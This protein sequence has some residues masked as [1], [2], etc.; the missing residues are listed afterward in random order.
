MKDLMLKIVKSKL[1]LAVLL[2]MVFAAAVIIFTSFSY[3]D[4]G[5]YN[6]SM[7]ICK[8]HFYYNSNINYI[9]AVIIGTV[10]YSLSDFNCFV[11]FMTLA[12]Y[13][14]FVSITFVFADKYNTRKAVIFTAVL[15]IIYALNHYSQVSSNSTAAL[16][17]LGGFMLVLNA[18]YHKRYSISCWIGVTEILFGSFLNFNY[19]FVALGFGVA[20]FLGDMIAKKKYRLQFQKFFWYSRPFFLMFLLITLLVLG[21]GRFS[22]SVNHATEEAENYYNYSNAVASVD[23]LP[24]PDFKTHEEAFKKAGIDTET[25]YDVFRQGYYDPAKG[26]DTAAIEAVHKIQLEDIKSKPGYSFNAMMRDFV[27]HFQNPDTTFSAMIVYVCLSLIFIIY[28]KN[29]FSFFPLFY[30]LG[31]AI[32]CIVLRLI[33]F[34][35][36]AVLYGVLMFMLTLLMESFNFELQRSEKPSSKWRMSNGYLI[37]STLAVVLAAVANTFVFFSSAPTVN[38]NNMPESLISD[39][40]RNPDCYYVIDAATEKEFEQYTENYLHPMWG[41]RSEYLENLDGFGYFH[42][43]ETLRRRYLPENI[44]EAIL[45]NRKIYVIDKNIVYKKE[46]Y[47]T[48]N[49]C[50]KTQ[51]ASYEQVNEFESYKIYEVKL[52]DY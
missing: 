21:M 51:Y 35:N 39:I 5:D 31:G 22:Y 44:Y 20:F 10:Q 32:T 19:F 6:N 37:A 47:L 42:H 24:F 11:L 17:L 43:D 38:Y 36:D 33:F 9:L 41:F 7:L 12:S 8:N 3:L 16:L 14:A 2:N 40:N 45:T 49:Y 18:I 25:K 4:S 48:E 52:K 46:N 26:M 23:A 27:S 28:H 34:I 50:E 13:A 15:N 29:R 30:F 1:L